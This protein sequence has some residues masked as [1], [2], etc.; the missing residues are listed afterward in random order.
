MCS[1]VSVGCRLERC[2]DV[3]ERQVAVLRLSLEQHRRSQSVAEIKIR[4][5]ERARAD[6]DRR[7]THL[8]KEM[9]LFFRMHGDISKR[10]GNT[11]GRGGGSI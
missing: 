4:N 1:L 10:G 8:Q 11:G 6:A 9:E 3:L 2:N 7:N 5:M